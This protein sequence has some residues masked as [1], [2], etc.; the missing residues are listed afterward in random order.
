VRGLPPAW[1]LAALV[2]LA[3]AE[4]FAVLDGRDGT[5]PWL[6]VALP[7][8]WAPER[9]VGRAFAVKVLALTRFTVRARAGLV[10]TMAA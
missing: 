2:A 7:S 5:I 10:V 9:K 4:D 6:A 3:F 1:R 8:F